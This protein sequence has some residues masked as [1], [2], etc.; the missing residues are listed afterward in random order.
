MQQT[1]FFSRS[2]RG[3]FLIIR[4]L[5]LNNFRSFDTATLEFLPSQNYIFGQNWQGKSSIVD[6]IGF[7]LF[8]VD[9]FPRKVA[10]TAVRVEHLVNDDSDTASVELIF[11]IN[12]SQYE[13]IRS[14]P[15]RDV[16]L[17][18]S[19]KVIATGVRTVAEKLIDLLG[20]DVKLFQN[21]FFSDQDDL[22]KS[23]DFSPEERRVFIERLL[24]V[25]EWKDKIESLRAVGRKLSEFLTDLVSG[26]LGAFLEHQDELENDVAQKKDELAELRKAIRQLQK[27][28]PKSLG[29]IREQQRD[30][31]RPI[32]EL[33]HEETRITE[34]CA[35]DEELI[36]ALQKGRCPT[37]TQPVPPKLRTVR[38]K[39]ISL[40]IKELTRQLTVLK[41][42]LVKLHSQFDGDDLDAAEDS[43]EER[44]QAEADAKSL[45]NQVEMDEQRLRKLRQ[46][47]KTFGKKPVQVERTKAEIEFINQLQEI[48]QHYRRNLRRRLVEPLRVGMND[49]LARFHDGDND[50]EVVI[51]GDLN[52]A[53]RLHDKEVPIFNL[54]G[55][56][57]DI[58]AL[59]LRYGLLR[60]A[61][62]G[63]NFLV[64]DEPTRHM[65]PSNCQ[66]LKGLFNDLLD[67]QLIVVTVNREFSDASG[68]HFQ[69]SKDQ[70]TMRSRVG[71]PW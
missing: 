29:A 30:Q 68:R 3:F 27:S 53:V 9:V 25:E 50:S 20:V 17:K 71:D 7:A 16:T 18:K 46:Q 67:R 56:A 1:I 36:K 59:S 4:S 60:V 52:I 12:G 66:R 51:D 47:A 49:F 33:Q 41:R 45:A 44:R 69:V 34:K 5:K 38:L 54:S 15:G 31:E 2:G 8:G 39:A 23:L 61:A 13:L 35:T 6:A 48:I 14:L 65:D 21:I 37:C 62:R 55:A 64:L 19:E 10:G 42:Q 43:L 24:G 32:A 22:R 40:E 28:A 11:E 58:L 63:I 70:H 57:K 26:R